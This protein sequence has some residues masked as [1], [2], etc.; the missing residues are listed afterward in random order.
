MA[1]SPRARGRQDRRQ[2]ADASVH[3]LGGRARRSEAE[4]RR[5]SRLGRAADRDRAPGHRRG[6]PA[7]DLPG[8]QRA[9]RCARSGIVLV[10]PRPFN[11]EGTSASSTTVIKKAREAKNIARPGAV[12]VRRA[13]GARHLLERHP[14][15]RASRPGR[16]RQVRREVLGL[17]PRE[18]GLG[19]A[20]GPAQGQ[21]R[22][23]GRGRLPRGRGRGLPGGLPR[24]RTGRGPA[25][26]PGRRGRGRRPCWRSSRKL[27][28]AVN[29]GHY[30]TLATIE[31]ETYF[32]AINPFW[33]APFAY[34]LALALLAVSLGFVA[35]AEHAGRTARPGPLPRRA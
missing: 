7:G 19:A 31:R 34:G 12:R 6:P 22:G 17:A 16:G 15:R 5:Q 1:H 29:P 32:N 25:P 20:Q 9:T 23:P 13:Q 18:L 21:A 10:M 35:G 28:E 14:A 2:R 33:Q 11:R 8:V 30:P 24:A 26:G 3:G 27:G 4:V